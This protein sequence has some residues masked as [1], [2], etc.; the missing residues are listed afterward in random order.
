MYGSLNKLNDRPKVVISY[1]QC[2]SDETF[3]AFPTSVG[4]SRC[5]LL[6]KG[7]T[8]LSSDKTLEVFSCYTEEGS[9]L[10]V[11]PQIIVLQQKKAVVKQHFSYVGRTEVSVIK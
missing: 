3:S 10:P 6:C 8:Y 7:K 11:V 5:S 2:I 9:K 1:Y 4:I